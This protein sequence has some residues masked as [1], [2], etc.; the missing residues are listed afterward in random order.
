[1]YFIYMS[2]KCQILKELGGCE[3][4]DKDTGNLNNKCMTHFFF[5]F[6]GIGGGGKTP[7]HNPGCPGTQRSNCLCLQR[8]CATTFGV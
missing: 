3:P 7:L 4:R 2:T 5:S 1:M 8:V 6:W